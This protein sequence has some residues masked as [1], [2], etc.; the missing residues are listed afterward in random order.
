MP[1][2][3][4]DEK[5]R[6]FNKKLNDLMKVSDF[7]GMGTVYYEMADFL[8]KEG[9][10]PNQMRE[11]GYKMKLR[12][13]KE[14]LKRMKTQGA[15]KVEVLTDSSSCGRCLK[16]DGKI[17]LIDHALKKNPLPIERC[18]HKYGCR[19]VYLPVIE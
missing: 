9:K 11:L 12:K 19:C 3:A 4:P 6:R 2:L 10:D 14:Q 18:V 17:F 13:Q 8:T 15:K 1:K 5:W 16:L 7:Y